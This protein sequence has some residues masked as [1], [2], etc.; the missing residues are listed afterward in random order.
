MS[1]SPRVSMGLSP[2][3]S[4]KEEEARMRIGSLVRVVW[5]VSF[6]LPI[7][8]AAA[9]G[10]A[11][12]CGAFVFPKIETSSM[13]VA[14][15]ETALGEGNLAAAAVK[16]AKAFPALAMIRPG[17]LPL[18]D[19][20][21]HILAVATARSDG[22]IAVSTMKAGSEAERAGNLEWS[23]ATLRGLSVKRGNSPTSQTDL[24]EALARVPAHHEEAFK[25]LGELA[26]KDLL[27]TAEGYAALARLRAEKGDA[28]ARD[29][30]IKRC[31]VMTKTPKICEVP[32]AVTVA[33][34]S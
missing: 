31:E 18:A 22:N 15:A 13:L 8:V 27:T 21:L 20:A 11:D 29:A 2:Y 19:R 24:G 32:A 5:A 6:L 16:A 23:I 30:A 14:D 7:A 17:V 25:I 34:T 12:A 9:P 33:A 10:E 3:G 28:H 26:D 1:V 4:T